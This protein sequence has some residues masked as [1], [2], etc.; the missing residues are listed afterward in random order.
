MVEPELCPVPGWAT[1]E[2]RLECDTREGGGRVGHGLEADWGLAG[3]GEVLF[4]WFL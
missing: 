1:G 2:L 3:K 4:Y